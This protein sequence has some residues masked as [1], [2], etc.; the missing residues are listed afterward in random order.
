MKAFLTGSQIYGI[1]KPESDVDLVIFTDTDTEQSLILQSDN[2]K[3]PCMYGNLNI[4]ICDDIRKYNAYL[5]GRDMCLQEIPVTRERAIELHK[6]AFKE[7]DV[8]YFK[9]SGE[10]KTIA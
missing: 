4:I 2:G 5:L 1:P 8:S 10:Y 3:I 9:E 7:L 6:Q